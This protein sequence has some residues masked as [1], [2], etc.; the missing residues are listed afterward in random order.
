MRRPTS[1]FL[2]FLLILLSPLTSAQPYW[3]KE[4][5]YFKYVAEGEHSVAITQDSS[6]YR[7]SYGELF[8]R[9]VK[10]ENGLV[11][12]EAVLKAENLT[13]ERYTELPHEEAL[14]RLNELI[15]L[16]EGK[17]PSTTMGS[18]R[19]YPVE[20]ETWGKGIARI[21]N[22]TASIEFSNYTY[23]VLVE[24][25]KGLEFIRRAVPK[26]V[27]RTVFEIDLRDNVLVYSGTP[28]GK[29]LLFI[30]PDKIP[31]EGEVL[32]SVLGQEVKVTKSI[33]LN[34]TVI[35][36]PFRT[37]K[38]PILFIRT[39]MVAGNGWQGMSGIYYDMSSGILVTGFMPVSPLWEAFGF[40]SVAL[41]DEDSKRS[42][43]EM[44][45]F[46]MVLADTNAELVLTKRLTGV[47]IPK[48]SF[49]VFILSVFLLAVCG[50]VKIRRWDA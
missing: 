40:S 21:C 20:N 35:H 19:L 15:S 41:F 36:T 43:G 27:R 25:D 49:I 10:V 8:W 23:A 48:L 13:E 37:F 11:T 26:I 32:S 29:N 30:L 18:C 31:R 44:G 5:V 42:R 39:N 45:G 46:G 38:P 24:R 22:E 2:F 1:L 3:L 47:E 14:K 17:E 9:V 7:G 33:I 6:T 34:D 16:Y 50:A 28:L 12:V 4:G